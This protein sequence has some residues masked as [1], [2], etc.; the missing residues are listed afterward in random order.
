M[1]GTDE[2]V[3]LTIQGRAAHITLNRPRALNALTHTMVERIDEALTVWEHDPTVETV[4]LTGA[5]SAACAR[6][7]TSAP[8]TRTRRPEEAHRQRSGGT[9]TG[10]TPVSRATRNR[11]SPSWTAS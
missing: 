4:V 5:G 10:S 7:V 2:P 6:A 1:T 11:T 3:L 8:S 9:N